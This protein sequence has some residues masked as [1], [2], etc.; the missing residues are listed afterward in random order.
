MVGEMS[1]LLVRRLGRAVRLRDSLRL[2]TTVLALGIVG[3]ALLVGG[4]A[5]LA[6]LRHSL[7]ISG[8][9]VA[10]ARALEVATLAT[11]GELPRV[12]HEPNEDDIV[13]VVDADRRVI[14]GTL[15][16]GRTPVTSFVPNGTIPAVHTVTDVP[17][18]GQE[19]DAYRVWALRADTA[20]GPVTVYIGTSLETVTDTMATVRRALLIGGAGLLA[21]LVVATLALLKRALRP[22]ERIRAQVA[23]ISGGALDLRV[24]VPESDDEIARLAQTMNAMLDRLEA[25]SE[26]QRQFVAD[27]SHELQS[28]L[29]SFRA[30]LEVSL[31]HPELTDWHET[32]R[33]LA[34]DSARLEHLVRDLLFL[35][36][37]D[38][39]Q[40]AAPH[41]PVDLDD[42]VLDE[43][44]RLRSHC[45]VSIDTTEVSAA[46]VLGN[47]GDLAR[48]VRNLV[49]NAVAHAASVVRLT[50]STVNGDVCLVVEDDGP[51]VPHDEQK[52]LFD[53][54]YRS[55]GARGRAEGGTGLGLAIAQ[56]I[57][58]DHAGRIT[59]EDTT[60]GARFVVVM[61]AQHGRVLVP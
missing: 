54:F 31:A 16:G 21:L 19:R 11:A 37:E 33:M 27:A 14:S 28:P 9:D 7:N 3:L 46:P 20:A 36:R 56:A 42:V 38:H 34:E 61:P 26:L 47:R 50:L 5:L 32:A 15:R 53:R 58:E 55:D 52:R 40:P 44:A 57:A 17:D 39:G 12:V 10:R 35:A 29:A 24:P 6:V 13:Q 4:I 25:A 18:D 43:A 59:I 22:V 30:Q 8:D 60:V 45:P 51:G 23:D 2:R 49:D 1:R 48:L 41:S